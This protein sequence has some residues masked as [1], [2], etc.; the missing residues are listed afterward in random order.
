MLNLPKDCMTLN[1]KKK[2]LISF[3]GG[4]TSA[5]MLQWLLKHKQD[6]YEMIVVFA[7][8]GEENEETLIFVQ[9]C[10]EFFGVEI[11]WVE[12]KVHHGVRKGTT[13]TVVNYQ[14]ASRNGEPF[15][16]VIKKYGIPNQ[17]YPHCSRELKEAPINSYAKSIGWKNYWTAIGVRIDEFDRVND[18]HIKL[19]LLYPLVRFDMQPMN[20]PKINFW[21]SVQPFRLMLKG[22]EGNCKTCWKKGDAKLYQI[23]NEASEKF[24]F[25]QRMEAKYS[26][27]T[28][29]S[30]VKDGK[31]TNVPYTFYRKNRTTQN[32][33]DEAKTFKLYVI[34]DSTIMPGVDLFSELE[35]DES[36]EVFTR[37]G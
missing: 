16:E 2:L 4:E 12:A 28:P 13:H 15:E 32:I 17:S 11:I 10:S 6:E 1:E 21:W 26:Y 5:Y 9:K 37:C 27:Y 30:R 14:S 8:T 31:Q 3:S 34:D 36:C 24:D 25:T 7:N 20:K 35:Q 22:Y 29:L 33:L 19:K 18:K 23:A